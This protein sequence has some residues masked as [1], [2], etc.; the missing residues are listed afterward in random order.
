LNVYGEYCF[1]VND[2]I[3]SEISSWTRESIQSTKFEENHL[4]R[5]ENNGLRIKSYCLS[6]IIFTKKPAKSISYFLAFFSSFCVL[7]IPAVQR[8]MASLSFSETSA[9]LDQDSGDSEGVNS[10]K[11]MF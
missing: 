9:E 6:I 7:F 1:P 4:S 10:S 2:F 5:Q 8:F 3:F 11:D